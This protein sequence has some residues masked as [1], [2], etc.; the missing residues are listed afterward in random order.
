MY[1]RAVQP[2][3]PVWVATGG[4]PETAIDTAR[5]GLPIA[6]AIIGG[7]P[8]AFKGLI[9][10]YRKAWRDVGHNPEEARV[11]SHSWGFIAEDNDKA[12]EDYFYPTK[13]LVDQ[14]A[15]ERP[16]WRPLTREQYLNS[17]GEHGAM[18]VGNPENVAKKIIKTIEELDIDRFMLHI[19]IGSMPHEQTMNAIRLFGEEVAPK[20]REYFEEK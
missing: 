12:I 18:F 20:V 11:A 3:L 19:P 1:P 17:V 4:S 7:E 10:L 8:A 15:T 13:A 6:F 16:H 9:D 14:L 2:K 5:R